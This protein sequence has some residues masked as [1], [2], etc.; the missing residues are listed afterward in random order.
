[1]VP[2]GI[3]RSRTFST[4]NIMTFVVYGALGGY[5]MARCA[6]HAPMRHAM[7]GGA[8]GFMLSV[9]LALRKAA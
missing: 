8:I 1:M 9:G 3:F 6:P 7:T 5:L 4:A 2:L